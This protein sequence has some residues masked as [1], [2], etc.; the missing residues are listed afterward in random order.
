MIVA[1]VVGTTLSIAL[2]LVRHR[3]SGSGQAV[4]ETMTASDANRPSLRL[5]M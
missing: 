4:F 5:R 2:S 3:A 1:L